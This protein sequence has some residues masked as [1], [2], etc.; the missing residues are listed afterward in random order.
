[1]RAEWI[2][3]FIEAFHSVMPGIGFESI[4]K[5]GVTVQ[6]ESIHGDGVAINIGVVGDVKGSVVYNIEAS[7]AKALASKM[8]MGMPVE[9]INDMSKSA[10]AE[11]SNMLTAHAS[12]NFEQISIQTNISPPTVLY[13]ED[14][15]VDMNTEKYLKI[16]ME[17]DGI[18]IDIHVAMQE[19]A[20]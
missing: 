12:N 3:P 7:N 6:T 4:Q 16:E 19:Q 9:E 18:L 1:M 14:L 10:L 5:K 15:W 13:G 20:A 11:L 8:M 17:A 2:N